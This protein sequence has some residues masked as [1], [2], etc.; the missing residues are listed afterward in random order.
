CAGGFAPS[1]GK[2]PPR[3]T[4]VRRATA[5]AAGL[6]APEVGSAGSPAIAGGGAAMGAGAGARTAG[7]GAGRAS[8]TGGLAVTA[9]GLSCGGGPDGSAMPGGAAGSFTLPSPPTGTGTGK[10]PGAPENAIVAARGRGA[11]PRTGTAGRP[12]TPG[13]DAAAGAGFGATG[14]GSAADSGA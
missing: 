14:A 8:R 9:A 10:A 3:P 12:S 4:T 7:A 13:A 1:A 2:A 5:R 6:S 11:V